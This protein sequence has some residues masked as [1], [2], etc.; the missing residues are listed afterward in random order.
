MAKPRTGHPI[1]KP[2][3]PE[4]TQE[5]RPE[6]EHDDEASQASDTSI[7]DW[8][9]LLAGD[10]NDVTKVV[11]IV[12]VDSDNSQSNDENNE[13][14]EDP[15]FA[16]VWNQTTMPWSQHRDEMRFLRLMRDQV[17]DQSN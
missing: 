4:P 11:D 3:V 10:N 5:S 6:L 7:K 1:A 9:K 17:T 14:D 16:T 8:N 2:P 12:S 15:Y 13:N